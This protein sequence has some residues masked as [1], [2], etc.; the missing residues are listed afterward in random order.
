MSDLIARQLKTVLRMARDI[1]P[2]KDSDDTTLMEV[3]HALWTI[4]LLN[5]DGAYVITD[6]GLDALS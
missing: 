2:I 4:G 3:C 6:R 5:Y 1:G